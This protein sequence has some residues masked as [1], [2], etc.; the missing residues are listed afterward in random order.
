MKI[1]STTNNASDV[2]ADTTATTGGGTMTCT[3]TTITTTRTT[4]TTTAP[5][6]GYLP[7]QS[8]P[9]QTQSKIVRSTSKLPPAARICFFTQNKNWRA[10]WTSRSHSTTAAL[11]VSRYVD[12]CW[13]RNTMVYVM[14]FSYRLLLQIGMCLYW[15]SSFSAFVWCTTTRDW[16]VFWCVLNLS[17]SFYDGCAQ[18]I[19]VR[20]WLY[21]MIFFSPLAASN[22]RVSFLESPFSALVRCTTTLCFVRR[23]EN[24][25]VNFSVFAML[26]G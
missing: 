14:I 4:T 11:S 7:R 18:C 1:A 23:H 21:I 8:S 24:D 19:P 5:L 3:T 20:G 6:I 15:K 2:I 25:V 12:G 22:R 16:Q 9:A 10:F 13:L 17:V 26:C